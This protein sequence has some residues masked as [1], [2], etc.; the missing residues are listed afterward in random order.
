MSE[1]V[2]SYIGFILL[3]GAF[4]SIGMLIS[5]LTES[6]ITAAVATLGALL[7]IWYIEPV[8][9]SFPQD[10]TSGLIFVMVLIVAFGGLI[11][12]V[13]KN[14]IIS[15]IAS[16]IIPNPALDSSKFAVKKH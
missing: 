11:Y 9:Q 2:S 8:V 14:Q 15:I 12:S 1:V 10:T 3:G 5:S 7:G 4:L 16:G 6:Q 13:T